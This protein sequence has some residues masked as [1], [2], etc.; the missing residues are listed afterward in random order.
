[1]KSF[2]SIFFKKKQKLVFIIGAP[3][4]GTTW[5]WSL[6]T[7][8]EKVKAIVRGDFEP[9]SPYIES[10]A[11]ILYPEEKTL[12]VINK[13]IK[14]NPNKIIIEKTPTHITRT[15]KIL[16]LFPHAKIIYIQRDPRA[17]ISSMLYSHFY[18]FAKD[19]DDAILKYKKSYNGIKPHLKN[20]NLHILYYEDL[21]NDT[22]KEILRIFDFLKTKVNKSEIDKS[23]IE[24]TNKVKVK[25]KG[26]FRKGEIDSYKKDLTGKQIKTIEAELSEIMKEHNYL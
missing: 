22:S 24:N 25:I 20:K 1:M 12:S 15:G 4:S 11:F 3:R 16:K 26:A 6:M 21:K 9:N 23:V 18:E 13:K 5:L 7:S 10:G 8:F 17:V 2:L 14:D 19:I